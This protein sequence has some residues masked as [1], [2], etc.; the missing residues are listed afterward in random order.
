MKIKR[1]PPKK[2]L[3]DRK[4]RVCA[5]ARV[6][7]GDDEQEDSLENQIKRYEELISSNAGW[8]FA[9]IY[10]DLSRTGYKASRKGFQALIADARA[11][12]FDMVM[13][14]SI[15]RFAR[16]TYDL[17]AA[18]RELKSMNIAVY[19]ELQDINTLTAEGEL[20]LTVL[21]AF[22]QGLSDDASMGAKKLYRYKFSR[23]EH[24][25]ASERTFGFCGGPD[26]QIL[27]SLEEAEIVRIIFDL[28][29]KGVWPSK[30]KEYLNRQGI[31]SPSGGKWDDTGVAR[32]LHNVMYKGDI[33]LQKTVK[34]G[35]RNSRP[36]E[37][38]A[39]QWYI[40]E[41]HEA[42]VSREQWDNVQRI[43]E[44]R[45]IH[46][47]TPLPA[48]PTVPRSPRT[49]YPLTNMLYC[50]YCGKKLI[51]KWSN[52]VREYWAC[53]TNIKVSAAACKGIWLPGSVANTWEGISEPVVVVPY[54]DEYGMQHF[55]AFPKDEF[56]VFSEDPE[57]WALSTLER[58]EHT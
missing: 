7:G 2:H 35:R 4:L 33:I 52:R 44:E 9:G 55:T 58:S 23:L 51:H 42:I 46:L 12:K 50:P 22:A 43:L 21:G 34:D 27:V 56:D 1:I 28:A 45:R 38:Q 39:D 6:S 54:R 16:N 17:L 36:N 18:T 24:T 49:K 53:R 41:D 10:Y 37:G 25:A 11:G 15:S 8:E 48:A 32:V 20:M 5:Y 13:V 29:E 26:G 31:S 19:F 40:K 57:R 30:I 3:L 47:D 14:K